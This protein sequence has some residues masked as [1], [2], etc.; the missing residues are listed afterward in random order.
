MTR[1]TF[2]DGDMYFVDVNCSTSTCRPLTRT[3]ARAAIVYAVACVVYMILTRSYGT[4]FSDSLT[5]TQ[6]SLKAVSAKARGR[7]FAIGLAVG[8][9]V[10]MRYP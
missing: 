5:P 2:P 4:P 10:A 3:L 7:A 1:T 9:G 8:L 6:R